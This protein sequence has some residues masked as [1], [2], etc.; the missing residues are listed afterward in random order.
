ML[1]ACPLV[2]LEFRIISCHLLPIFWWDL[3]F[4][5]C[6]VNRKETLFP[7]LPVDFVLHWNIKLTWHCPPKNSSKT[8]LYLFHIL[9]V[10]EL[11]VYTWSVETCLY[12]LVNNSWIF[13]MHV[14]NVPIC[15]NRLILSFFYLFSESI[16]LDILVLILDLG[17]LWTWLNNF[18]STKQ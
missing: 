1:K 5:L 15:L 12:I 16:S 2:T 3:S 8:F 9:L 7:A 10:I 11:Y 17:E 13:I 14:L 6:S 4:Y 18:P